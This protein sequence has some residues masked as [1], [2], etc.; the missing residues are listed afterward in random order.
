MMEHESYR[1]DYV[2]GLLEQHELDQ[3]KLRYMTAVAE[4]EA[5]KARVAKQKLAEVKARISAI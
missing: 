1:A 2:L 5:A 3:I 4:S